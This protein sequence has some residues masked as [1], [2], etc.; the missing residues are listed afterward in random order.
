MSAA[1][2]RSWYLLEVRKRSSEGWNLGP[3]GEK[4][5]PQASCLTLLLACFVELRDLLRE[6]LAIGYCSPVWLFRRTKGNR[7]SG[8]LYFGLQL[9][10]PGS[11]PNRLQSAALGSAS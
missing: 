1:A 11:L 8:R 7:P 5:K 3:F 2:G 10:K 4:E 9:V 6:A